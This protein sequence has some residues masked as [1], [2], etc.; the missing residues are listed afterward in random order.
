MTHSS[1]PAPKGNKLNEKQV[2][3][4]GL[5]ITNSHT[6]NVTQTEIQGLLLIQASLQ[7]ALQATILSFGENNSQVDKLKELSQSLDAAQVQAQSV[8]IEDSDDVNITQTELQVDV[9]VQAAI[10]LLAKLSLGTINPQ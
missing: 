3:Y 6:V 5:T 8:V 9:A 10:Q 4:Q 2:E 1:T 7:A